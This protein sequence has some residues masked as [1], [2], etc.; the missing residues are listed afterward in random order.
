MMY[1]SLTISI[2]VNIMELER[3]IRQSYPAWEFLDVSFTFISYSEINCEFLKV[4]KILPEVYE[5]ICYILLRFFEIVL[6]VL[7]IHSAIL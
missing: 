7:C 3:D 6:R 4:F 2:H 5:Y 1:T